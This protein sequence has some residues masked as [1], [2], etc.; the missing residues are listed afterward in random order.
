MKKFNN[1][2]IGFRVTTSN[3]YGKGHIVRCKELAKAFKYKVIFFTDP[4]Y[5]FDHMLK[6]IPESSESTADNAIEALKNKRINALFFDNY[7]IDKGIIEQS[8][9]IGICAVIDDYKIQWNN[10]L[11]FSTNLGS[12]VSHYKN[13]KNVF[14]GPEYALIPKIFYDHGLLNSEFKNTK[15]TS[16]VLIQM[17]AID[18]KNNIKRILNRL[19][20]KNIKHITVILNKHAPHWKEIKNILKLFNSSSLI[21][22]NT[23]KKMIKLYRQHNLIIGASG[24]SLIER[25]SL[26]IYYLAFSLNENQDAN[27]KE[28]EKNKL[29]VNGGRIDRIKD[30]NLELILKNFIKEDRSQYIKNHSYGKILDGQGSMRIA[31]LIKEK[32]LNREEIL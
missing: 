12:K 15:I 21:E 7:N 29:G 3:L 18:S 13:N 17:G 1:F 24:L 31:N 16:H 23:A 20:N 11:I 30:S 19:L 25:V 5:K 4:N 22:V 2:I 28:F 10:P 27:I 26:G 6:T 14:A 32:I 8:S 9:Q